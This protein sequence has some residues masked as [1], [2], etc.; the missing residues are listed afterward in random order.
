VLRREGGVLL[1]PSSDKKERVNGERG[2]RFLLFFFTD[3]SLSEL[4]PPALCAWQGAAA[5]PSLCNANRHL[6]K[7]EGV[8]WR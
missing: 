8:R 5:H 6:L 3:S 4:M 7:E 2:R 1:A